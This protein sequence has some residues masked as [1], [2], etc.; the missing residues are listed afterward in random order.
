[1][2]LKDI[3]IT[4]EDTNIRPN[5]EIRGRIKVNYSG[6]YDSIVLN[7]Q[8]LNSNELM[9]F[10]SCNGKKVSQKSA[11]LFISRDSMQHNTAE[12][13]AMITFEPKE[14]HDVKFRASII[15]QHKEI[16][17]DILFAKFF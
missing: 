1:M 11:R 16:E 6:N 17:S 8:I 2:S 5:S 15:E 7:T 9:L 12:F 10:T 4:L 14:Q 3:Q 13:T